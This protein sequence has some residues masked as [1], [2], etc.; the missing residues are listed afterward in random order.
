[1]ARNRQP[2]LK[3][4]RALGIDPTVLGVNKKSNRGPRPNVNTKP[5]EYAVQL[6]EKQKAKFV[7]GVME[8]Q[9]YKLY[10]EASRK[11]GVTGENLVQYLERRLDNVVYRLGFV[12]TR[13]Q[14]R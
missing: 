5:T 6:K 2:I 14:A 13:K 1:M 9:F 4:C 7:Y 12:K 8:K 3:K 11:D 10:E